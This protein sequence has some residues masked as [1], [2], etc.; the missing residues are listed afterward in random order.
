MVEVIVIVFHCLISFMLILYFPASFL[1]SFLRRVKIIDK[2]LHGG[3]YYLKKGVVIDV[4]T[5]TLCDVFLDDIKQTVTVRFRKILSILSRDLILLILF[6]FLTN[7]AGCQTISAG[8]CSSKCRGHP[9]A[10]AFR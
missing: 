7:I 2:R 6:H 1:S 9:C 3:K 8:D 10:S 5:P 4:K